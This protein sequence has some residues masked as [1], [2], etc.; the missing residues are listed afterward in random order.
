[1]REYRSLAQSV[2]SQM[3]SPQQVKEASLSH[4]LSLFSATDMSETERLEMAHMIQ[5]AIIEGYMKG[6][7]L[8]GLMKRK[9]ASE[10]V[11][12]IGFHGGPVPHSNTIQ[13]DR[14]S[15]RTRPDRFRVHDFFNK[16]ATRL[17]QNTPL[18]PGGS[19]AP[20]YRNG[21]ETPRQGPLRVRLAQQ[22]R[23]KIAE[24]VMRAVSPQVV[25]D[26]LDRLQAFQDRIGMPRIQLQASNHLAMN[27][28][29][30]PEEDALEDTNRAAVFQT[31][32]EL[33]R[34]G[35]DPVKAMSLPTRPGRGTSDVPVMQQT[36]AAMGMAAQTG[37]PQRVVI[38]G[39]AAWAGEAQDARDN[40]ASM[41]IQADIVSSLSGVDYSKY[42]ALFMPGGN[43][44]T[45]ANAIGASELNRLKQAIN[46]GLNYIGNCAG[47]FLTGS[48]GYG[49][50]LFR[51]TIDYPQQNSNVGHPAIKLW[52][53]TT[54]NLDLEGGPG[55]N[56]VQKETGGR[57]LGTWANGEVGIMSTHYGQGYI[58]LDAF[59]PGM[60]GGSG[61]PD[62]SDDEMWKKLLLAAVQGVDPDGTAPPGPPGTTP[63]GTT[64]ITNVNNPPT[65]SGGGGAAGTISSRGIKRTRGQT[66]TPVAGALPENFAYPEGNPFVAGL[67][68]ILSRGG[69]P[70]AAMAGSLQTIRGNK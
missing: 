55:L 48:F 70:L 66:R 35:M 45:E 33:I 47:T 44:G 63:P 43:A 32:E 4:V 21:V 3:L 15:W 37:R 29:R 67:Q 60:G 59:H 26:A 6:V 9:M 49:L 12:H 58:I 51:T 65:V 17:T 61:D 39:G 19:A 28:P 62:G 1:M 20:R 27:I 23:A 16:L 36:Q 50:G 41:G 53:G 11:L 30:L 64:D 52:D 54:R 68:E 31:R 22:A 2:G 10:G 24:R 25:G 38:Y 7:N 5:R 42:A 46:G 69:G 8:V 40:L 34:G 57:I 56:A 18:T 14:D 13:V